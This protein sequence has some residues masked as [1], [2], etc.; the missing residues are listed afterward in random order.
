[1]FKGINKK[2][3][4]TFFVKNEM[5]FLFINLG[6]LMCENVIKKIGHALPLSVKK[7]TCNSTRIFMKH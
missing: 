6:I 2:S 1:M 3:K 4:G 7:T 5:I